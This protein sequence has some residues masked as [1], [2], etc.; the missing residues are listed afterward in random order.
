MPPKPQPWYASLNQPPRSAKDGKYRRPPAPPH[1]GPI[2]RADPSAGADFT[3]TAWTTFT[4]P[5]PQPTPP[6]I[7]YAGVR[8][9]EIIGYRMWLVLIDN[10]LCSHSHYFIWEPGATIEGDVDKVVEYNTFMLHKPIMGG[11]YSF[12]TLD[13]LRPEAIITAAY[14]FPTITWEGRAVY[15]LAL[16]TIKCWG[17]VI[18][19]E[20]GWRAQYAKIHSIDSCLGQVDLRTI[21]ERYLP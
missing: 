16:G 9:G 10:R 8:A 6:S 13:Q 21:Q 3:A 5:V 12:A 14:G 18:E 7:P 20:R 1:R 15:G 17:E 19:H 2:V 11:V 4:F